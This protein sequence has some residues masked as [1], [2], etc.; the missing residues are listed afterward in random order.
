MQLHPTAQRALG[1]SVCYVTQKATEGH[2]GMIAG[3]IMACATTARD[4]L[5]CLRTDTP[6]YNTVLTLMPTACACISLSG[7][8]PP[9]FFNLS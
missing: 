2:S 4:W 1:H 7:R 8:S 3:G 9:L 6:A 5:G